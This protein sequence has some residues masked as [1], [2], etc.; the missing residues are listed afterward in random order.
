MNDN[1]CFSRLLASSLHDLRNILAVIRESAGL[2]QDVASLPAQGEGAAAPDNAL[3]LSSLQE[4]QDAVGKAATLTE[5]MDYMAQLGGREGAAQ[6]CDLLR[7]CRSFCLMAA[8]GT[9]GAGVRLSAG[10]GEEPVW[11]VLPASAAFGA[12]HG[13]LD[14]CVSVGGQVELILSAAH[15]NGGSGETGFLVEIGGGA[16][17]AH[18]LAAMTGGPEVDSFEPGWRAALHP[19][20]GE[21]RFFLSVTERGAQGADL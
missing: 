12:L 7:V 2:A 19:G 9:R 8:R 14:L 17:Q 10:E 11:A 6:R 21:R 4:A 1:R 13:V 5:A 16:N 3:L 20:N 18:V 15:R